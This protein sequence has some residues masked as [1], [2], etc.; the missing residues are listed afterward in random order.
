M[1]GVFD[2]FNFPYLGYK[3]PFQSVDYKSIRLRIE[4]QVSCKYILLCSWAWRTPA[5]VQFQSVSCNQYA[6]LTWYLDKV[7]SRT[8]KGFL[9]CCTI[10]RCR[11]I[12]AV[13]NVT[14]VRRVSSII[15]PCNT[16]EFLPHRAVHLS[17]GLGLLLD[18]K[19]VLKYCIWMNMAF[20][21][22]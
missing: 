14:S 16:I 19:S 15:S 4:S 10:M 18:S 3:W 11:E 6:I 8:V 9:E 13:V 22:I 7:I 21:E 17:V 2:N 1:A 5:C 12:G 20:R